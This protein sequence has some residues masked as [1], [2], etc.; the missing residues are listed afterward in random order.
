M[1]KIDNTLTE[2]GVIKPEDLTLLA[3]KVLELLEPS[4]N[5][6][7]LTTSWIY[8]LSE[9][10]KEKNTL[11]RLLTALRKNDYIE[12]PRQRLRTQN[13][14]YKDYVYQLTEK[15]KRVNIKRGVPA[16]K[17]AHRSNSYFHECV[18]DLCFQAPLRLFGKQHKLFTPAELLKHPNFPETS[19]KDDNPF[20]IYLD[21]AP[22]N[23]DSPPYVL[24]INDKTYGIP[25][26]QTDRCTEGNT[27]KDVGRTTLAKHISQFFQALKEDKFE[28][29]FGMDSIVFPILLVN[30]RFDHEAKWKRREQE[31]MDWV[32]KD[33]GSSEHL[34]FKQVEEI[35]DLEHFPPPSADIFTTPWK[36]V[37]HSDFSFT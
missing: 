10:P 9:T 31:V 4:L 12:V 26:I 14:D 6:K 30:S 15:G 36:R 19:K 1:R 28:K 34:L 33:Y 32:K 35:G 7:F 5:F 2:D 21:G 22:V 16:L 18:T 24:T 37:G 25:G 17:R 27:S 13:T 8:T 29:K 20:G 11:S 3:L 23:Y